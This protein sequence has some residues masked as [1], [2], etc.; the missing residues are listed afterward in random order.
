MKN[1]CMD[2]RCSHRISSNI[3]QFLYLVQHSHKIPIFLKFTINFVGLC[4]IGT[5]EKYKK[6]LFILRIE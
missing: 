4:N 1:N 5:I 6:R 3:E 2:S